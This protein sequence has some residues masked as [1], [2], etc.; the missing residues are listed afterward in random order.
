MQPRKD[1][2][3]IL[4]KEKCTG[5]GLCAMD[6]PTG[7]LT[8]LQNGKEDT[9]QLLF[10]HDLC[11]AC[12]K[13]ETSCPEKCLRLKTG[14]EMDKRKKVAEVIFEDR[15]CRCSGCGIPLFPQ[16]MIH[17]LKRKVSGTEN[18]PWPFDLCPSC[19]MKAEFEKGRIGKAKG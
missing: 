18:F 11:N 3:P 19:R 9:Y 5:C 14:F 15:L 7:A 2:I 6:C 8:L 10:R 1:G 16:A 4:D 17:R 12:G 13:C